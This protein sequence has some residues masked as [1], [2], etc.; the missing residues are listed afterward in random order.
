MVGPKCRFVRTRRAVGDNSAGSRGV[1]R[2]CRSGEASLRAGFDRA[3]RFKNF[4]PCLKRRFSNYN[5]EFPQLTLGFCE[6]KQSAPA[7]A[8]KLESQRFSLGLIGRLI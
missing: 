3:G 2:V 7:S 6:E 1:P 4:A 5:Y 8:A